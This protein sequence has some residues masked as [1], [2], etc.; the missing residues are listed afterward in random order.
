MSS[1][2]TAGNKVRL[3]KDMMCLGI[4]EAQI[5]PRQ[6]RTDILVFL[7]GVGRQ[8]THFSFNNDVSYIICVYQSARPVPPWALWGVYGHH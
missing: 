3:K 2:Y 6:F 1:V 5:L 4:M 8:W 7:I